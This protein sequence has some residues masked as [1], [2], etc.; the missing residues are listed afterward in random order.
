M[1]NNAIVA[2][3]IGVVVLVIGFLIIGTMNDDPVG[4]PVTSTPST[5]PTSSSSATSA[6]I[7]EQLKK[8]AALRA[9]NEAKAVAFSIDVSKLSEAQQLT[10]KTMGIKDSSIKITNAMVACAAVDMSATRM[11]E[12]KGGASITASEGIKF[13]SCYNAN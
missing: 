4:V 5:R 13:V 2:V 9:E 11:E 3:A 10:L 12:I 7:E 1:N 6:Q 8:D